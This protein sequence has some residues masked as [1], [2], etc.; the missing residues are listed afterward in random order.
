MINVLSLRTK[1]IS[2][3]TIILL[4]GFFATNI[5]NYQV[6]KGALRTTV[7]DNE[8]P[9]SSNNVYSEI[10]A[11]LLR[12]IFISSLMA[13]DTFVHEWS[14][15]GEQDPLRMVRYL[16][17]IRDQYKTFTSYFISAQTLR[18]YHFE[19]VSR[20]L[21]EANPED[22]WF[23]EASRASE[24]YVV[25]VDYNYQQGRAI[26][27]FIN[28]RVVDNDGVFLG[29]TGVGLQLDSVARL[30]KEYQTNFRRNVYFVDEKGLI[31]VHANSAYVGVANIHDLA[32][33]GPI[34]DQV[35]GEDRGSYTYNTADDTILLTTR[36]IPELKWYLFIELPESQA[37]KD[38][39]QGFLRNLAIAPVVIVLTIL[40]IGYSI[41][42]F[43]RRLEEMA[44]T[45]KLTGLNNREFFDVSLNQSI[46][47]FHRDKQVFTLLMIDIDHFKPIN[48]KKG[49]LA[50][51]AVIR[52]AAEIVADTAR[53]SDIVCR[54]GGEEF[55]I[56]AANC[57]LQDAHRLSEAIHA[58][59]RG[60]AFFADDPDHKVTVSQ[61]ITEVR[62]EDDEETLLARVD[63]AMYKAKDTGRNRTEVL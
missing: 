46:K 58:A 18:Y 40:L 42:I 12:P 19:G 36:Y 62:A 8:L 57:N 24:P 54:W 27:I 5:L 10:Q 22:S 48:D 50:G 49:H 39:Q 55:M 56:L 7:L 6:S 45:D 17:Q 26:T 2:L 16:K 20:T 59:I 14:K 23:F 38:M 34:T 3:V 51:D 1:L 53:E 21:D 52:R 25:N 60:E 9:L 30:V 35:L 15:D 32:G 28:Y 11:D 13:N 33:L 63:K 37:L 44:I 4:A 61:G 43:Q 29:I 41:N 47:R 31:K